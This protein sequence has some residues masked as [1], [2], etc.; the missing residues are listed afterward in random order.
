[1]KKENRQNILQCFTG[2]LGEPLQ[3]QRHLF[4][5][6][7]K[8]TLF[9]N[10]QTF[11]LYTDNFGIREYFAGKRQGVNVFTSNKDEAH[12]FPTE[13]AAVRIGRELSRA[14]GLKN[15]LWH[16]LPVEPG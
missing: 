5:Y 10:M 15:A 4:P 16:V 2:Y 12:E 1:M 8:Y 9:L 14:D 3:Q 11:L 7:C 13:P 6:G